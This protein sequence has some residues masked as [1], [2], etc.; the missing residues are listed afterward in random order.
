MKPYIS[1][2]IFSTMISGCFTGQLTDKIYDKPVPFEA[3][4][5]EKAV[6]TPEKYLY[7]LLSVQENSTNE[8]KNFEIYFNPAKMVDYYSFRNAV[9]IATFEDHWR[10]TGIHSFTASAT[11]ADTA[12]EYIFFFSPSVIELQAGNAVRQISGNDIQ[13]VIEPNQSHPDKLVLA[14]SDTS[15]APFKVLLGIPYPTRKANKWAYAVY[16]FA[17][18]ADI[19]TAPIQFVAILVYFKHPFKN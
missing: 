18:A 13:V 19:I 2:I 5:I 9:I 16:P 12:L 15:L 1:I 17:I 10:A 8:T 3:T 14:C 4:R 7:V 6:L 11:I